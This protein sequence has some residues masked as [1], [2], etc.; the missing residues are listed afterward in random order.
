MFS[1]LPAAL[2]LFI[3]PQV[4]TGEDIPGGKS[5]TLLSCHRDDFAF[6]VALHDAPR[7]LVDNEGSLAGQT[8]IGVGLGDDPGGSIG[9]TL[10]RD[11]ESGLCDRAA[12][13]SN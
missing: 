8:S 7:T 12:T 3:R 4:A 10:Q 11:R 13:Q 5:H 1:G 9:D 6:K 2:L